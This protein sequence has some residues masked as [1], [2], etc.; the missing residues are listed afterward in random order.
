[1]ARSVVWILI[2]GVLTVAAPV[3]AQELPPG[4]CDI[5]PTD[6]ACRGGGPGG[7]G[8]GGSEVPTPMWWG[9]AEPVGSVCAD[10]SPRP[11]YLQ[12][13]VWTAGPLEGAYV[14]Q[15]Q[16]TPTPGPGDPVPGGP[17]G[18]V[19]AADGYVYRI[20]CAA[21][22]ITD[23]VWV[24]ARRRMAPVE[25]QRDPA[26]RGLAGLDTRVWYSGQTQVQPF[27]LPWVDPSTGV[28]WVLEARAWIAR[29][30]WDF[31]DGAAADVRAL[32]FEDA[33]VAA[34]SEADPAAGHIYEVSSAEF[35]LV[36]GFPFVFSATWVGEYRWSSDG[37]STWS[38][39]VP[40]TNSFTD[41][42]GID[43]EVIQVRS[44]ITAAG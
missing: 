25:L 22:T 28:S 17:P 19:F 32:V 34:G 44:V 36:D 12:R 5:H 20:V 21:A 4:Y 30:V 8:G 42:A 18:A 29:L 26:I 43:Y 24:E 39:Y 3:A 27:R 13:L 7:G 6:P 31:G 10:G 15:S 2:I 16:F 11:S 14:H 38:P 33:V 1:M 35:G 23:D 41:V 37:G 9:A 40:M